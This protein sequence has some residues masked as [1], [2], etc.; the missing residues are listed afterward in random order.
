MF[1]PGEIYLDTNGAPIN[2]HGAGFLRHGGVWYWFGEH[3]IGGTAGNRAWVGVHVYSSTDLRRWDDRGL[4]LD[5]RDGRI[6]EL[7]PGCVIERPKVIFRAATGKFVMYFH[8]E[9]L[10]GYSFAGV[11][12]AVADAPAGPYRFLRIFRP[13]PGVWPLNAPPELRDPRR[14]A[15]ARDNCNISY[16]ENPVTPQVS[17]LG[18]HLDSGQDSRDMTLF[19][20]DDGTAYHIYASELNSTLHIAELTADGLDR[21]GRYVRC[22]PWRWMEAPALFKHGGR[23]YLFASGCTGWAPNAARSATAEHIFGPWHE[24]GNPAVDEGGD[25]T[26]RSQCAS[27]IDTGERLIYVGDRWNPR[28]AADGRYVWLPI[29]FEGGRPVIHWQASWDL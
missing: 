4:A 23:Y 6:P 8:Y 14:I 22:F 27:V 5:I 7:V 9:G 16:A 12:T 26:Y 10:A 20:D 2:A 19:V 28:D 25:T 17:H 18:A 15:A 21:T 13:D 24:L 29:E 1:E 3:K 11:G